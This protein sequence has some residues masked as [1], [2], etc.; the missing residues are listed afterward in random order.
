M[1]EVERQEQK[2]ALKIVERKEVDEEAY[3][4]LVDQQNLNKQVVT[5]ARNVEDAIQLMGTEVEEVDKHPE[6]YGYIYDV[7]ALM[8]AGV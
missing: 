7:C 8:K 3:A 5:E 4:A 2:K 1:Q 6:R